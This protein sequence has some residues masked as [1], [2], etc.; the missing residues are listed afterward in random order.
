[1][2]SGHRYTSCSKKASLQWVLSKEK[3]SLQFS[4]NVDSPRFYG[5]DVLSDLLLMRTGT[6]KQNV[7]LH[8]CGGLALSATRP[9]LKLCFICEPPAVSRGTL[10]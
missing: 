6:F 7:E 3:D 1:M 5:S 8:R 10:C 2:C 4:V 9:T